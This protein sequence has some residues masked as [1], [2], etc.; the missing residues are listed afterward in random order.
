MLGDV[1]ISALG[2]V[3]GESRDNAAFNAGR[4]RFL[5]DNPA[6]SCIAKIEMFRRLNTTGKKL[7]DA[8][9]R[10]GAFQGPF[11][12]LIVECAEMPLFASIAPRI[13]GATDPQS[14][15]QVTRFFVYSNYYQKFRHDVRKFLDS[16]VE[17]LNAAPS[18]RINDLR[19]EFL[20]VMTFIQTNYRDA[21]YRSS[22]SKVLPR[23]RFEA[24]A[25]GTCLAL[26]ENPQLVF[27]DGSWLSSVEFQK[28]V[29]TDAS[30]SGPR[31][32]QRVEFVRDRLL[33]R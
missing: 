15:R 29:R 6:S 24:I 3:L 23:V 8:E 19:H 1:V 2:S 22:K 31:L 14:A 28:M 21:F 11:L 9:I 5:A 30:N 26:R 33:G 12:N 13:A 10:K 27:R 18:K 32:T 7:Q 17:A 20:Q 25:V 4:A 16:H